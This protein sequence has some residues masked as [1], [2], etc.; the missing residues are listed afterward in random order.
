[1][2]SRYMGPHYGNDVH[3]PGA[4]TYQLSLLV[5]PP[6]SARHVEYAERLA[7]APSGQLHLPLEADHMSEATARDWNPADADAAALP[8]RRR[9][10]RRRRRRDRPRCRARVEQ[11]R[12]A[13]SARRARRP[14]RRPARSASTPGPRR[15]PATRTATRSRPGSTGCC[16]STSTAPRASPR[17]GARGR[18]AHA[19]A[20]LPVGPIGPAVHRRMG[21]RL[22][23]ARAE[24]T[25]A[26]PPRQGPLGLRAAGDRR[27]RPLPA[28]R[29]RRRSSAS[30]TSRPR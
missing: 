7:K 29:L 17:A 27:L 25:L 2:I 19:R 4:G 3:V 11:R 20:H 26:D 14:A 16:S 22:L 13:G 8:P 6:V 1:M 23:R 21:S 5:S 30:R 18:A 10:R 9:R 24:D 28:L 15:W 12:R